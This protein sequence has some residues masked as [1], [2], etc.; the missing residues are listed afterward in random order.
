[1]LEYYLGPGARCTGLP[2]EADYRASLETLMDRPYRYTSTRIDIPPM[3]VTC[4]P[5]RDIEGVIG[6]WV[7]N[8]AAWALD[9]ILTMIERPPVIPLTVNVTR[10]YNQ[11]SAATTD[12]FGA[13]VIGGERFLT[14]APRYL[15]LGMAG[16]LLAALS[17][18]RSIGD[19]RHQSVY[20]DF[21]GDFVYDIMDIMGYVSADMLPTVIEDFEIYL[22]PTL[23]LVR[24]WLTVTAR[25]FAF[26]G[27]NGYRVTDDPNEPP[28]EP[29]TRSHKFRLTGGHIVRAIELIHAV[30]IVIDV[31]SIRDAATRVMLETRDVPPDDMLYDPLEMA[32][33]AS[34][35]SDALVRAHANAVERR[36]DD[37]VM[38]RSSKVKIVSHTKSLI[39][40]ASRAFRHG[41]WVYGLIYMALRIV[42][43]LVVG[44]AADDPYIPPEPRIDVTSDYD[45]IEP[46]RDDEDFPDS[47]LDSDVY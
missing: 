18:L 40:G 34:Y 23:R 1:M 33:R 4:H 43:R 24:P 25:G 39:V 8:T 46:T 7:R 17:E 12:A 28:P 2:S 32:A 3:L 13:T 36:S 27:P 10:V 20:V 15:S 26:D 31:L 11:I 42:A 21:V 44:E 14:I 30:M 5:G 41:S 6:G 47:P 9:V 35:M 45:Q 38:T 29:W 22:T 37:V 16:P 19:G